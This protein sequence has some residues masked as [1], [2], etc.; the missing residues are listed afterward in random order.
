MCGSSGC[1][2]QLNVYMSN[3]DQKCMT[4][5]RNVRPLF[6][7]SNLMRG[8]KAT[9]ARLF[10]FDFRWQTHVETFTLCLYSEMKAAKN[11]AVF[12]T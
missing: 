11:W 3:V 4:L 9:Q 2:R 12:R 7:A 10:S 1:N 8:K 5:A 6:S